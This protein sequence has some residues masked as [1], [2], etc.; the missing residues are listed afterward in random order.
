MTK[1]F[2]RCTVSVGL[3]KARPNYIY[4]FIKQKSWIILQ[5]KCQNKVLIL[6]YTRKRY[7][8][9]ARLYGRTQL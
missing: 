8:V 6:L 9:G 1:I 4:F 3:A 5:E 7:S 2:P